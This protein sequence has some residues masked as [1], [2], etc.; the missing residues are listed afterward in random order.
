M[1]AS[2]FSG[3]NARPTVFRIGCCITG[4]LSGFTMLNYGLHRTSVNLQIAIEPPRVAASFRLRGIHLRA[5][6]PLFT[7][8]NPKTFV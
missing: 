1:C 7:S 5:A 4:S 2:F 6:Q 3:V 8:V